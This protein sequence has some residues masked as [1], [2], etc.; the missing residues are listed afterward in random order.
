MRRYA[1]DD[2]A[3]IKLQIY[4]KYLRRGGNVSDKALSPMDY[5]KFKCDKTKLVDI[6]TVQIDQS[7]PREVRMKEFLRQI[8]NPYLF[9]VGDV[10]VEVSFRK[11][12]PALQKAMESLVMENLGI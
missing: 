8:K 1:C 11:N 5:L 7:K 3:C 2:M 12:G 4:G 9:K 10:I 6:S